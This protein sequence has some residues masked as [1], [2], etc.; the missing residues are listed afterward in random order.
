MLWAIEA[1]LSCNIRMY[2]EYIKSIL[3]NYGPGLGKAVSEVISL[4]DRIRRIEGRR[5]KVALFGDFYNCD[6]D[7]MNQNLNHTIEEAGG[8]VITTPYTDY[9]KMMQ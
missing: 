4:F 3:E 2:P 1:K 9:I 7:L 6:N 5:Q 8:E